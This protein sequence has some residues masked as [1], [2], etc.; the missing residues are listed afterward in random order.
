MEKGCGVTS[1]VCSVA[2][3][4]CGI[5]SRACGGIPRSQKRIKTGSSL[6][7][8]LQAYESY[9]GSNEHTYLP[10]AFSQQIFLKRKDACGRTLLR[11]D[12]AKRNPRCH[13]D[14]RSGF[15]DVQPDASSSALCRFGTKSLSAFKLVLGQKRTYSHDRS[16]HPYIP[17]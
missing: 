16:C 8:Q 14:C 15:K 11:I 13:K 4:V 1:R 10:K 6:N 3:R 5:T 9:P 2:S 7:R 12:P 17:R